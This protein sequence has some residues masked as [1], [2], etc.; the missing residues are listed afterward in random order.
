M[1]L[2]QTSMN[3]TTRLT[4]HHGRDV[5][6]ASGVRTRSGRSSVDLAST[7]DPATGSTLPPT[8]ATVSRDIASRVRN[9]VA[10]RYTACVVTGRRRTRAMRCV[11]HPV[12][13][14]DT[15]RYDAIRCDA[16]C[17][18][19]VRSKADISQLDLPHVSVQCAITL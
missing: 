9:S 12:I 1:P 3:A 15:I 16:R 19:N 7:A 6:L 13:R 2:M 14:Y 18:F 11:R 4:A 5:T 17:Y 8:P 10:I